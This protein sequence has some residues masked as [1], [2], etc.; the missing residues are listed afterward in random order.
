MI[1]VKYE[2]WGVLERGTVPPPLN[3]I[4]SERIKSDFIDPW[5]EYFEVMVASFE[6]SK[7]KKNITCPREWDSW[8][9]GLKKHKKS[10]IHIH[11]QHSSRA[12][13][14]DASHAEECMWVFQTTILHESLILW[15]DEQVH[16]HKLWYMRSYCCP[17]T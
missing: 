3:G 10:I 15:Y 13:K 9:S 12:C 4:V 6:Q 5:A 14:Y 16:Y 17:V 8:S 7:H 11:T 2:L 1:L